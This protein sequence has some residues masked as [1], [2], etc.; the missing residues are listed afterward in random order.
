MKTKRKLKL[1]KSFLYMAIATISFVEV[2]K[3][4]NNTQLRKFKN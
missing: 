4:T 2:L 3:E 1:F